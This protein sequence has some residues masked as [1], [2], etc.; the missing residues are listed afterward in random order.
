MRAATDCAAAQSPTV[1][2]ADMR[3]LEE[4]PQ[5]RSSGDPRAGFRQAMEPA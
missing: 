2:I 3:R 4:L 1:R 5:L